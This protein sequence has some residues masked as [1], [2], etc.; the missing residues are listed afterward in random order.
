MGHLHLLLFS[1]CAAV[2]PLSFQDNLYLGKGE[3]PEA[4]PGPFVPPVPGLPKPAELPNGR[5]AMLGLVVLLVTSTV[6]QTPILDTINTGLGG[7]LL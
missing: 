2:A 7:V 5:L 4:A 3:E 1:F 6:T